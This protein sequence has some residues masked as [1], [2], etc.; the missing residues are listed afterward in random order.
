M[1]ERKKEQVLQV[2]YMVG[3]SLIYAVGLNFLIIPL[4]L[5]NGGFL[6]IAQLIRTFLVNVLPVPIPA[7]VDVSGIIYFAMNVPLFY[8]GLRIMGKAFALK[9][10]FGV[11]ILSALLVIVPIPSELIIED[12]LTA[13]IIG[14]IITGFG[15]GL[16]LRGRGTAGGPDIIGVCCAKR[17]PNVSVGKVGLIINLFVYGICLFMFNVEIV[18]Y[19]I[20]Y[21]TVFSMA[22]DRVHIQNINMS[23]MIFTKKEGISKAII[24]QLG[25]GVTNWDGEGAY[26]KKPSYILFVMISKYEVAQIKKIVH[27]IDPHAFMIFTEGCLVDG[28]FE[29]R[30]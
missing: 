23:V 5:Y 29:K 28:N 24:E 21:A 3:G 25:R 1:D 8:M 17:Y 9:S 12:Y 20:I 11:G 4:G 27:S 30:L 19:S 26:T 22:V 16:I 18:V 7:S 2:A 13:C 14:G 6:G 15:S 10:L